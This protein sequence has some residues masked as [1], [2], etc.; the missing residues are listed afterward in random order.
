VFRNYSQLVY[1]LFFYD[2]RI[3][4]IDY[5][6]MSVS[7]HCRT[8]YRMRIPLVVRLSEVVPS[9]ALVCRLCTSA[10]RAGKC[11]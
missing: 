1:R 5:L 10:Y 8:G 4:T 6:R 9:V 7:P 3:L 11:V 2:E